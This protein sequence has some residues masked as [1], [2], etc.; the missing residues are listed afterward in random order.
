M[1]GLCPQA[2]GECLQYRSPGRS[3]GRDEEGGKGDTHGLSLS[4]E[5]P[6]STSTYTPLAR[7]TATANAR[8]VR[9]VIF[10]LVTGAF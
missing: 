1:G 3:L 6:G 9:D 5:A 4:L 10:I 2:P 8:R 7:Y